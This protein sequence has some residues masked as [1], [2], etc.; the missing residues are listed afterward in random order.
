MSEEREAHIGLVVEEN[1]HDF[2][3]TFTSEKL[4]ERR[5]RR[6]A[7]GAERRKADRRRPKEELIEV[8]F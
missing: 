6:Q 1:Y 3:P 7:V 8:L 4:W 5:R 2:G